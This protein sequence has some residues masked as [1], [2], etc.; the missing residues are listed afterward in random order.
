MRGFSCSRPTFV[1]GAIFLLLGS[2]L[3]GCA[4][5]SEIGLQQTGTVRGI[6]VDATTQKPI[7]GAYLSVGSVVFGPTGVDGRFSL[8]VP[9]GDQ[10]IV[11][12]AGG[13][14]SSSATMTVSSDSANPTDL[15]Q[16]IALQSSK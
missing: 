3:A 4:D 12:N 1:I 6:V 16:P 8:T 14:R 7:Q 15:A 11:A 2:A 5:P 13:Y 10:T 9:T